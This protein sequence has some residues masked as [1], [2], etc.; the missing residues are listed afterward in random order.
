MR[1]FLLVSPLLLVSGFALASG[2]DGPPLTAIGVHLA[3][4]IVLFGG[5]FFLVRKPVAEALRGRQAEVKNEI[6]T[7]NSLR[8][9]AQTRF[10]EIEARL[11]RFET[12]VAG[13]KAQAEKEAAA[14][15]EYIRERTAAD[16][17]AL[18]LM[19]EQ[20]IRDESRKARSALQAEA[21]DLAVGL[22]E[23]RLRASINDGDQQ[24][25]A[26]EFLVAVK[27]QEA[28]DA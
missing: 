11:S 15:R 20:T 27:G 26:G 10:D 21:V 9:D 23:E 6:D 5:L 12:E 24:R 25:L 28:A 16:I 13:L 2:G 3:N 4:F 18:K 7:S 19:T 17:E 14:D 1:R 8:K 22:A